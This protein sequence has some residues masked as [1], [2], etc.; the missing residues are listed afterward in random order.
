[1]LPG[2]V[3]KT[4]LHAVAH[5]GVTHRA[6]DD[7]ADRRGPLP[8][9]EQQMHHEGRGP[10]PRPTTGREAEQLTIGESVLSG[11]HG[12]ARREAVSDRD[13]LAALAAARAQDRAAGAG[14]HAETETVHLVTAAVVG[15]VRALAHDGSLSSGGSLDVWSD[16][17]ALTGMDRPPGRSA[18]PTGAPGQ[19][20]PV[21]D[22][23]PAPP[24][25]AGQPPVAVP[26]M[27]MRHP[28]THRSPRMTG[29][30]YAGADERV[31][32]STTPPT[33]DPQRLWRTGCA[34]RGAG[35]GSS[36]PRVPSAGPRA[37]AGRHRRR[38]PLRSSHRG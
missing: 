35:L 26:V 27:D 14:A 34:P 22:L 29:Q 31:K 19:T 6:A 25:H 20:P 13:A 5:H 15:L 36:P 17:A 30:R 21:R 33:R 12:T 24:T 9:A 11:E 23:R 37:T 4:A 7:E 3:S 8:L 38:A 28:S 32:P 10:A 2:Q 1:M 16:P 18:V